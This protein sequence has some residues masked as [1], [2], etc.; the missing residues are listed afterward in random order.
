VP[1]SGRPRPT[2]AARAPSAPRFA[3]SL[4][5]GRLGWFSGQRGRCDYARVALRRFGLTRERPGRPAA[6]P[7]SSAIAFALR[8]RP[9]AMTAWATIR[10]S[11]SRVNVAQRTSGFRC[12]RGPSA[13]SQV[14]RSDPLAQIC[15]DAS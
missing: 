6:R 2:Q 11:G 7:A 5:R 4:V 8:A 14:N 1:A 13:L 3:Q 12:D 15:G 9:R 10:S